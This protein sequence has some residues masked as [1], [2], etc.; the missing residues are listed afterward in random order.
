MAWREEWGR[1][2]GSVVGRAVDTWQQSRKGNTGA[3]RC[4]QEEC[5]GRCR[6]QKSG[7]RRYGNETRKPVSFYA[8]ENSTKIQTFFF[9]FP[10]NHSQKFPRLTHFQKKNMK[11]IK[12]ALSVELC[13][14]RQV[15]T[16]IDIKFRANDLWRKAISNFLSWLQRQVKREII[17]TTTKNQVAKIFYI[18]MLLEISQL[19]YCH[20]K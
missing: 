6:S 17:A 15:F 13:Y 9:P 14:K 2:Y 3:E 12:Q 7:K 10:I 1:F 4:S 19:H 16:H 20:L 5:P 8:N 18:P 11:K